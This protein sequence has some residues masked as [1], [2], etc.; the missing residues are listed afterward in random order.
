MR[1][2][3]AVADV[4]FVRHGTLLVEIFWVVVALAAPYGEWVELYL[5]PVCF[6]VIVAANH[7]KFPFLSVGD[8]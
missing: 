5:V 4:V 2:N 6:F 7:Q 8:R 1:S 3:H